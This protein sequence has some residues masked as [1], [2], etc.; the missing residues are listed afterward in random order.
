[1]SVT[2]H[3]RPGV[4]SSYDASA[5]VSGGGGRLV[6]LAAVNTKAAAN[7]AY[8]VTSYEQ[9]LTI[10]GTGG[11]MAEL[12]RLAL[13]NGAAGVIAA[14]AATAAGYEA[15]FAVL[16]K[17]ENI[18]VMLCDSGDAGVHSKLKTSVDS[19]SA[20]R[21]ERIAV[22]GAAAGETV[23]QLTA[24]AAALNHQRVVLVGPGGVSSS[25]QADSGVPLAAA[26]GGAIAAMD[27]PAVPLGGQELRGLNGVSQQY[28][29][30]D[31]DL[32]VRG[33]VTPLESVSGTVSVVRGI[34]T[35]TK[36]GEVSDR[37]WRELTTIL[38][39]D[40]VIPSIRSALRSKFSR[41]K[42]TP[43][44][45]GAIRAQVVLELENK[46]SREIIT[47]Y[48]NVTVTEKADDPTVCLVEFSFT[49]AHGLNQI[50][51]TAHITV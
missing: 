2:T 5:A 13:L 48:D 38:V 36:T 16:E 30:N 22:V 35:R 42:N 14:A 18:C 33:G 29:D 44:S 46:L 28:S 8:T 24:R 15:A 31:I 39:V 40:D 19:A 11:R 25:G 47:A 37:T 21:R 49:A 12:I 26:V 41:A 10:F 9:A 43:Q 1:M 50:W 23:S 4:Y 27:D 20:A 32:L 3:E 51:L 6:G 7:T 45:R 34:T 17:E